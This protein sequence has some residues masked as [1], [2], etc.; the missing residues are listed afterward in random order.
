MTRLVVVTDLAQVAQ[1]FFHGG[2]LTW[3]AVQ[4]GLRAHSSAAIAAACGAAAEVPAKA[5]GRHK[6]GKGTS[7]TRSGFGNLELG[8]QEL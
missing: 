2:A 5:R 6:L 1:G 4:S 3:A 7:A 8:P